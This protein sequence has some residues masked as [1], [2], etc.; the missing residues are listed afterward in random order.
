MIQAAQTFT[1]VDI[2]AEGPDALQKLIDNA[3]AAVG[4]IGIRSLHYQ[5]T[6]VVKSWRERLIDCDDACEIVFR[7]IADIYSIGASRAFWTARRARG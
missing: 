2:K 3:A 7:H 4:G 1:P 6:C 5:A